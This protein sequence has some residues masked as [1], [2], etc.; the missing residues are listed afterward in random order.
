MTANKRIKQGVMY[1]VLILLSIYTLFPIYFLIVNSFKSQKEIVGSPI[2]LPSSF[3]FSYLKNA[4]AQIKAQKAVKQVRNQINRHTNCD[5]ANL[6]K[7]A[8]ANAQTLK[9]IRFLKEQNALETLPEVLQDA[10]AKRLAY[11]DLS[12]TALCACFDPAVSK[13]GLSHRMKKLESLADTLRQ[14]LEQEAEEVKA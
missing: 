13:S 14:R 1:V 11:P 5:T 4:A 7:T 10:A 9:A 12:L 2:S 3:D 8:R 6:S